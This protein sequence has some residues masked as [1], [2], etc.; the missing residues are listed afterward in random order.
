M[1][2]SVMTLALENVTSF[3]IDLIILR[4]LVAR[5][6]EPI[7]RY[8][9]GVVFNAQQDRREIDTSRLRGG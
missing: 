6:I 4:R 2:P 5:L 1:W 7:E 3:D 9:T 8:H